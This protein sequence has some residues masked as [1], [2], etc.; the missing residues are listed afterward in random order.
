MVRVGCDLH[1]TS[2]AAE[3]TAAVKAVY[4]RPTPSHD[5][6]IISIAGLVLVVV[7]VVIVGELHFLQQASAFSP[8][9]GI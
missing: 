9:F 4:F 8:S 7:F 5:N 1:I 6:M 3:V 2:T